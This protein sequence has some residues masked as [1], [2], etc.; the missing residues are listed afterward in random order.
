MGLFGPPPEI[1]PRILN[2]LHPSQ[3]QK[4]PAKD[5]AKR[6]RPLLALLEEGDEL[7]LAFLSWNPTTNLIG[8]TNRLFIGVGWDSNFSKGGVKSFP[9]HDIAEVDKRVTGDGGFLVSVTNV[10]AIPFKPYASASGVSKAKDNYWEG[11]VLVGFGDRSAYKD[12]LAALER[13]SGHN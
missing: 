4:P 13:L 11:S 6:Q 7:Q 10:D 12:F 5:I 3:R 8:L 1:D 9:Y 2:V